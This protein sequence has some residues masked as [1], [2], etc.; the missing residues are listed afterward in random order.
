MVLFSRSS[1][2]ALS[3]GGACHEQQSCACVRMYATQFRSMPPGRPCVP[4]RAR[5]DHDHRESV[6]PHGRPRFLTG[7]ASADNSV[8]LFRIGFNSYSYSCELQCN[9]CFRV[10]G[11]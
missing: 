3:P 8:L 6:T 2:V 1:L 5:D 11:C 7:H 4:R 10:A 9:V